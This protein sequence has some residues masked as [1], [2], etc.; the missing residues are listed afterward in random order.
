LGAPGERWALIDRALK[1]GLRGLPGGSSLAVVL[2]EHRGKRP[3][4]EPLTV[5]QILRWAELH[6]ERT[7]KWPSVTSG[8]VVDAQS[9]N[10]HTLP[11]PRSAFSVGPQAC[12][13]VR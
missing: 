13:R 8:P 10:W 11:H 6:R 12:R 7:G 9:E 3:R 2:A 1:E 5:E 4:H